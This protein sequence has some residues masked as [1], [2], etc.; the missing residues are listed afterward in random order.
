MGSGYQ[1]RSWP[2]KP[3]WT[4]AEHADSGAAKTNST[5]GRQSPEAV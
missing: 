5:G 2:A 3:A 1:Q 4:R